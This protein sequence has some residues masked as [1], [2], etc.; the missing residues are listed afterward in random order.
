MRIGVPKEILAEEKRVAATP[1][2]VRKYIDLGFEVAV[3][4]SAGEGIAISD[5]DYSLAGATIVADVERL[6][7][8][9]DVILKVKQPIFNERLDKHEVNMLRD[10]SI[11]I[12]FL[13]PAAPE[14]R[15]VRTRP[16]RPQDLRRAAICSSP[17]RQPSGRGGRLQRACRGQM[18][19]RSSAATAPPLHRS[20]LGVG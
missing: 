16:C 2:T 11:L 7:A 3:E 14:S 15:S 4:S 13:H 19:S 12:T 5:D 9:S 17:F 6:L 1:E 20:I 10:G 18:A 8:E